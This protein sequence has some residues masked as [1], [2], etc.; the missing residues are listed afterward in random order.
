VTPTVDPGRTPGAL[1]IEGTAP[2]EFGAVPVGTSAARTLTLRNTDTTATSQVKVRAGVVA[3]GPFGV[4][5]PALT[6]GPGES[7]ALDVTFAPTAEGHRDA[8]VSVVASATNRQA[9]SFLAHGYGGTAPGNGPTLVAVPVYVVDPDVSGFMP[10]GRPFDVVDEVHTCGSGGGGSGDVCVVDGDCDMPGETCSGVTIP[11]DTAE[12]CSDGQS[13]FLLS[14]EGTFTEPNIDAATER[15]VTLMR[16]DVDAS[17]ATTGMHLLDRTTEETAHL[18]CDAIAAANGGLVYL[19]EFHN[20]DS[21]VNCLRDEREA[22]L[23]VN[24]TNG[25]TQVA[26]GLNRIDAAAGVGECADRDPVSRLQVS[27]D[28]A[29][30]LAAFDTAGLWRILPSALFLSPDVHDAFALHPDGSVVVAVASDRGTMGSIDL[31]RI[32]EDQAVHG[33][34]SL[35]SLS[36]CA[37]FPVPNNG[38]A[39]NDGRTLATALV[40]APIAPGARDA[41]ALVN[42]SAGPSVPPAAV[43]PFGNLRGTVAFALPADATTCAATGLTSLDGRPLAR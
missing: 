33:A 13:V 31:Y 25:G 4:S 38:V 40:V 21:T 37:T 36:P 23:R 26:N 8:H 32:V 29:H 24:K 39:G 43:L 18:A 3:A 6:L 17:G 34:L 41:T 28:G 1:A 42:F 12:L 35:A 14:S 9:V 27:D 2:L 19:S 15:A 22:L 20:V 7:A 30:L 16:V 5:A 10:D 11:F